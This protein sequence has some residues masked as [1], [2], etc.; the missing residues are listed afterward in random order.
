M[1]PLIKKINIDP[2]YSNNALTRLDR[3]F[4]DVRSS[5]QQPSSSFGAIDIFED[6]DKLCLLAE[7]PGFTID[8]IN[9]T[10]ED[11]I[12]QINANLPESKEENPVR[13]FI[14]QRNPKTFA[15]NITLPIAVDENKVSAEYTNGVLS[16]KM[17]KPARCKPHKIT[18]KT[19]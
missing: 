2:T 7:L 12:L 3:I 4:E 6:K 16:I 13:Y 1:L 15:K 11:G 10:L 8:D 17:E 18:I 9:L 19:D 5:C 14:R